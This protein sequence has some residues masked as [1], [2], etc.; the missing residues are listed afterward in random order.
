MQVESLKIIV[1]VL[2]GLSVVWFLRVLV[3]KE[4][5]NIVRSLLVCALLGGGFLYLR[6]SK[7]ETLH[8]SDIR[9]QFKNTFF[10]EKIPSYIFHKDEGQ[11]VNGR[12]IRYFFESP[13]P[14]LSLELDPSGKYFHIRNIHS[15]N[16]ILVYLGLPEVKRAVPE[17]ASI[18]GSANDI[19]QYRWEDY[20][21]GVLT[22]IREIC[23]DRDKLE[24]YQC[25]SNILISRR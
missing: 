18:T 9:D 2:I 1:L 20:E 11:D 14:K 7:L 17:L 22:I 10:P 16:R 15:I 12:F 24:S 8:F 4:T 6:S 23:Q 3:K 19:D 25:I 13:G 21:L 5:E